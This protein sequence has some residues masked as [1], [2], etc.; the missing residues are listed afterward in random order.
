MDNKK[1]FQVY[2]LLV[3]EG[4]TE[5]NL[6]SYLKNR[7]QELFDSSNIKFSDKVHIPSADITNG[8]LNGASNIKA[9]KGKYKLIKERYN[10]KDQKLFFIL[11]KDL[12]DSQKIADAIKKGKD[13]VQF[14]EYNSEYL[15]LNFAGKNP[16]KPSD[17][18]NLKIF[19]SYCKTEFKAQFGKEASDFKGPDFDKILSKI[20]DEEVKKVFSVLFN[21]VQ[22]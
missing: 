2:Y 12:D 22:I 19:R 14:I 20:G 10:D 11:D 1:R 9:F 4:T 7:F 6:F 15:L 17:F 5:Y 3:S 21:T 16:K 13:L 18:K 8:K